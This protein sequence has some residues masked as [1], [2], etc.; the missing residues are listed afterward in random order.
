MFDLKNILSYA[1][2]NIQ[3]IGIFIAIIGGLVATKLLNAKIE[4]D[5]LKEKL[6]K[7]EKEINFN[8]E[9][10]SSKEQKIYLKKR[11]DYI[12]YI[13][14]KIIKKDFDVSNYDDY[15]LTEEQRLNIIDEIKKIMAEAIKIFKEKHKKSEVEKIL[16]KNHIKENTIEYTIYDYVGYETGDSTNGTGP[17]GM[18]IPNIGDIRMDSRFSSL[19]ENLEERDLNNRIDKLNELL[20]WKLIEKEDIEAKIKAI[21]NSLNIKK[22]V[23]LFI[24]ITLFGIVV[25]QIVLSVYPIFINYK[26]LKYVFAI[27]SIMTFIVSMLA[28]LLY[29]YRLCKNIK[30]DD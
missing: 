11:K 3:I 9:K 5:T 19:Q 18:V 8:E 15:D 22:D 21:N 20:K 2:A 17:F 7:I 25:P 23:I 1:N 27:Y 16:K 12:Y 28:M 29:I 26:W 4:K 10:K 6:N 13:Y 24:S 14:D 30:K